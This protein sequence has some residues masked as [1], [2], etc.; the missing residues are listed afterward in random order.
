M[1][2]KNLLDVRINLFGRNRMAAF[3]LYRHALHGRDIEASL[4]KIS[5]EQIGDVASQEGNTDKS[6]DAHRTKRGGLRHRGGQDR[7]LILLL[8]LS[9]DFLLGLVTPQQKR[10][11]AFGMDE[12]NS[13]PCELR[14]SGVID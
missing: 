2:E 5:D 12:I 14:N 7:N 3:S 6:L 4:G 1:F 8:P 13:L 9:D 11:R 10:R